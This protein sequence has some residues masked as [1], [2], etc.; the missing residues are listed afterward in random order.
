MG[1][2]DSIVHNLASCRCLCLLLP[3]YV[4][5]KEQKQNNKQLSFLGRLFTGSLMP[6]GS[7]HSWAPGLSLPAD[8][9]L[10]LLEHES[11]A[12]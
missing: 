10:L 7:K 6:Q 11:Y 8:L 9:Q 3:E 12:K 2:L 1:Y 4:L 5:N